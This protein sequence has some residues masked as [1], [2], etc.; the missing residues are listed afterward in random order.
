MVSSSQP[1]GLAAQI[2]A[3]ASYSQG[4]RAKPSPFYPTFRKSHQL[5]VLFN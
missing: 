2:I 3:I 5:C 4:S 1:A